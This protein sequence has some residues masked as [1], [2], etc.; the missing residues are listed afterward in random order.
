MPVISC[1]NGF[2]NV[3]RLLVLT[4]RKIPCNNPFLFTNFYARNRSMKEIYIISTMRFIKGKKAGSQRVMNIAKSLAAGG[5]KVYLCSFYDICK[6]P[7]ECKEV[8]PGIN[9]VKSKSSKEKSYFH[10]LKFLR[11]VSQFI[12]KNKSHPVIYLYPTT[13]IFKDFVYLFYFKILKRLKFFCEINE[14]RVTNAFVSTPPRQFLRKAYYYIYSVYNWV[15]Y[16]M[17]ELLVPF[18]DGIVVISTNL[19]K[20]FLRYTERIIRVPILCDLNEGNNLSVP[21]INHNEAFRLCFAG[22]IKIKKEGFDILMHALSLVNRGRNVELYLYGILDKEDRVVL[23]QYLI[24]FKLKAK[25]FYIG[26]LEPEELHLEFKKYHLLILPR[27]LNPQTHYGFSTKLSEYLTSGVPILV[28]DVSDNALFIKDNYNGFIIPP[29]SLTEMTN[30]I[31]EIIE[32][33]NENC[34]RIVQHAYNTA[35]EYFDYKL[36]TNSLINFFFN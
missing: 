9:R 30:K 31:T 6:N 5:V 11:T 8:I 32:T 19:E 28:T 16:K 1:V 36:Y 3:Y 25:V 24:L 22:T 26:N 21:H 7:I 14:L 33:Y 10:L 29:G 34:S 27:P 15:A 35:R 23:D 17:S 20:Y 2:E 13:F 4:G 18:C 12:K